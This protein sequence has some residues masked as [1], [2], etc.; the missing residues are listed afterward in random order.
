[1]ADCFFGSKHSGLS[2]TTRSCKCAHLLRRYCLCNQFYGR[3]VPAMPTRVLCLQPFILVLSSSSPRY[4]GLATIAKNSVFCLLSAALARPR[5][6]KETNESW[7][8]LATFFWRV[9]LIVFGRIWCHLSSVFAA[10]PI[11]SYRKVVGLSHP[12]FQST[13]G[14]LSYS[15][16]D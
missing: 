14:V 12:D 3:D 15:N 11:Y 16:Q 2:S 5:L 6:Q 9:H 7:T 4:L 1:M 13:V 10:G 8:M